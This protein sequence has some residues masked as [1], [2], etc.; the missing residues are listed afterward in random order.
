MHAYV[1]DIKATYVN[2]YKLLY[3][4]KGCL[5]LRSGVKAYKV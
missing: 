1:Y 3:T 2:I 4:Y 5:I